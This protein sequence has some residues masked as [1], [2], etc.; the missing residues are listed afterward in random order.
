MSIQQLFFSG[1]FSSQLPDFISSGSKLPVYG[2]SG[3]SYPPPGWVG[4][5]NASV[6]DGWLSIFLPFTFYIAGNGYTTTYI[7]S[8]TYLTFGS[9]SALFSG[10]SASNPALPKFMF[11]AFDNSFQRVSRFTSGTDYQRIR[12]EGTASTSGTVGSPNIVLE[13]TLFNPE[14]YGGL[15]VLELLTG[16][17]NRTGGVSLVANSSTAYATYT[18]S[19]FRSYVF[20]GNSNG[21]SWKIYTDYYVNNTDY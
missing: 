15:N 9:G 20:V 14:N 17:H 4:V 7:S 8:N 19:P 11:G 3:G 1:G 13:I 2:T 16:D 5:Q 12:Y 21:T 6:D 10:L 18:Q